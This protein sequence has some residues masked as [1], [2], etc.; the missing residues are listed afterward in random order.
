[1]AYRDRFSLEPLRIRANLRTGVVADRWLPLDG[2]LLYQAHRM[3]AGGG[4]EA[5]IPGEY[6][7]QKIATL[8]L[9]IVHPG[10]KNWYYQC[11]WAQWS[12]NIEAQDHWNKRFDSRLADLIDFD[13]KR[14]NVIIKSGQYKAYRMPIFYRVAL[15]IDWYCVGDKTEIEILL[16]TLT[17]IGKK[18]VQGWGRV[19]SWEIESCEIDW[20]VWR[21]GKLM[22]GIPKDD[23]E[24]VRQ[25]S[26]NPVD[27]SFG[28]YGIRPSYWKRSN[29]RN[30]AL[31][32]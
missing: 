31:P 22:R 23:I 11:S 16:S 25:F 13:G 14:G 8:P 4:P 18:G 29:Q 30:L 15:Q 9:G 27:F 19:I 26:G 28:N 24:A 20:S 21:D 6:T 5:T 3:E 2:I 17:H 7:R 32:I 1:M 10:R 12:H